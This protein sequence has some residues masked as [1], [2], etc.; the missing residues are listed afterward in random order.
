MINN[1]GYMS[2]LAYKLSIVGP[3]PPPDSSSLARKLDI[4]NQ[5]WGFHIGHGEG[6]RL[7]MECLATNCNLL[8]H[9]NFI[10][11]LFLFSYLCH[12]L[13]KSNF[14]H[15]PWDIMHIREYEVLLLQAGKCPLGKLFLKFYNGQN[16]FM[17]HWRSV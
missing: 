4:R 12:C 9:N 7:D 3:T 8:L 10:H 15:K 6:S 5:P 17:H 16:W 1:K 13:P 2:P 11:G 14:L